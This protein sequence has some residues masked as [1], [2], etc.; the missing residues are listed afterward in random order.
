MKKFFAQKLND[1]KRETIQY[2]YNHI[3]IVSFV[4]VYRVTL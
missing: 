3:V 4:D 1:T 2:L